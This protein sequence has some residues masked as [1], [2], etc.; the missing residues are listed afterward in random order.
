MSTVFWTIISGVGVFVVGQWI[1]NFIFKPIQEY[2]KIIG[3]IDNKLKFYAN[4][5]NNPGT[6]LREDLKHECSDVLRKLSCD[7]EASRKQLFLRTK[8]GDRKIATAAGHI[9]RL[10]NS[11]GQVNNVLRN[12]DDY[13]EIRKL[14]NI[15]ELK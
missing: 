12:A 8:E 5:I 14:L 9:I 1:Q 4:V 6:L 7:L 15:P 10:S 2:K 13:D 3:S 11:L